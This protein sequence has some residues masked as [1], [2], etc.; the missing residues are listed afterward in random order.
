M[1]TNINDINELEQQKSELVAIFKSTLNRLSSLII[2]NEL[3]YSESAKLID[4][5]V[6]KL[7]KKLKI[8]EEQNPEFKES[9]LKAS[10]LRIM[11]HLNR[12]VLGKPLTIDSLNIIETQTHKFINSI[13]SIIQE[14]IMETR[15]IA[16]DLAE[17]ALI[18]S[19][20]QHAFITH[21]NDLKVGQ[22]ITIFNPNTDKSIIVE[23]DK[24]TKSKHNQFINEFSLVDFY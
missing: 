15:A 18:E 21:T 13:E 24:I 23:I 12:V 5:E 7:D 20:N 17:F 10:L 1:K 6:N 22:I 14:P 19:E 2:T 16:V 8:K 9:N 11:E 4:E 3:V